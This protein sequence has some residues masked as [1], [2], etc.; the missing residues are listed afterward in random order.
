LLRKY[1]NPDPDL[2]ESLPR[3]PPVFVDESAQQY[4]EVEQILDHR[5]HRRQKQYL[6]K[7]V[8]YPLHDATWESARN[9]KADVPDLVEQYEALNSQKQGS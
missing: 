9:I 6:V 2:Q 4:Y 7:W 3:P 8:G 1:V 5:I